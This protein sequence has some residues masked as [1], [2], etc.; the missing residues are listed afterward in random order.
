MSDNLGI[1][2]E[3]PFFDPAA[4]TAGFDDSAFSKVQLPHCVAG[5]SSQSWDPAEWE[6]VW[7]Y[8]RHFPL[9]ERFENRLFFAADD[10]EVLGDCIDATRLVFKVVDQYGAGRAFGGGEIQFEVSG[11]G[12]IVG[13]NPFTLMNDCGGAGA[14]WLKSVSGRSGVVK[15]RARHSFLGEKS[16]IVAI[17]RAG[18]ESI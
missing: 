12:I 10:A 3:W 8:R 17:R 5:L 4:L 18:P 14:V 7:L 1:P 6:Y 2:P 16:V 9:P 15:V 11:P 13:D